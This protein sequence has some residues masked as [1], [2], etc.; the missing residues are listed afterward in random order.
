[1]SSLSSCYKHVRRNRWNRRYAFSDTSSTAA[2]TDNATTS[3]TSGAVTTTAPSDDAATT[4][5]SISTNY[6]E[7]IAE[8]QEVKHFLSQ[9]EHIY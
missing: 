2:P 9:R 6:D 8:I 5:A 7:L 3:A 1:M 4:A